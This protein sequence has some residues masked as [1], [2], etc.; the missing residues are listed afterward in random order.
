VSPVVSPDGVKIR[1]F[2]ITR[3]EHNNYSTRSDIVICAL[4]MTLTNS[5]ESRFALRKPLFSPLNQ[6]DDDME[7]INGFN[8]D[9]QDAVA[10][11]SNFAKAGFVL[12]TRRE[13]E[14]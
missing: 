12:D 5:C 14:V 9:G 7:R 3:E 1:R 10:V 6:G 2:V 8:G 4:L 11:R 13:A